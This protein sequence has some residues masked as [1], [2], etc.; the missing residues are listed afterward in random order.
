MVSSDPGAMPPHPPQVPGP[1]AGL[2]AL[3]WPPQAVP[4]CSLLQLRPWLLEVPWHC[5]LLLCLAEQQCWD[6]F[7]QNKF[8]D[9]RGKPGSL[10]SFAGRAAVSFHFIHSAH[11]PRG[12]S[13]C[14]TLCQGLGKPREEFTAWMSGQATGEGMCG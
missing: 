6:P 5:Q 4:L 10:L 3:T 14:Q 9:T 2:S 11:L 13:L 7:P 12:L 1:P 8:R